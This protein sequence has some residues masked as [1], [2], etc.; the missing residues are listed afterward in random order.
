MISH[1]PGPLVWRKSSYSGSGEAC[2]EVGWRTSSFSG[3]N[4]ACVEVSS[5]PAALLVRDSKNPDGPVLAFSLPFSQAFSRYSALSSLT[6]SATMRARPGNSV[7]SG[8]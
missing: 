5:A 4:G 1:E 2:V 7:S 3:G 8:A 6:R